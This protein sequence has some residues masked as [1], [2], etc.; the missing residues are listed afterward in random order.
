MPGVPA[1]V[2]SA[3]SCPARIRSTIAFALNASSKAGRLTISREIPWCC[4]RIRVRRVSSQAMNATSRRVLTALSLMS[5]RLPIGVATRKSLPNG[6]VHHPRVEGVGNVLQ[7]RVWPTTH[8]GCD[9]EPDHLVPQSVDQ[10]IPQGGL[11]HPPLLVARNR[12]GRISPSRGG[13]HP[14]LHEAQRLVAFRDDVQL[15]LPTDEVTS[16]NRIA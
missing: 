14:H 12:V 13:P 10:Q 11:Q 7:R 5:E 16:Q 6:K 2:T 15:A 1:S 3:Q 8:D 4:R 9:I